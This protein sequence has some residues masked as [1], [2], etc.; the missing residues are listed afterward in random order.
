MDIPHRRFFLSARFDTILL[1]ICAAGM[2]SGCSIAMALNGHADPDFSHVQVGSRQEDIQRELGKPVATSERGNG[3][4]EE[5]YKYEI[6][7][8]HNPG[9]AT[10]YGYVLLATLGIAE[11]IL[12]LIELFQ[13][14]DEETRVVYDGSNRALEISGYRPPAASAALVAAQEAQQS[15]HKYSSSSNNGEAHPTRLENPDT[16]VSA[17]DLKLKDL[18]GRLASRMRS[19]G[20][21]RVAVLPVQ[22][23]SGKDNL[24]FGNYLTEKLTVKLHEEN[25]GKVIERTQLTKV[26]QEIA[27]THAGA[28]DEG[29][30]MRIGKLLGVEAVVT[31]IFADV[32]QASIEVTSKLVR[33]ETG[34]ILGAGSTALSRSSVERMLR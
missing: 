30:V 26:T 17:V 28:F 7:N 31:T 29:S 1:A 3:M 9:R 6:G 21:T 12:S 4:R 13:G 16:V 27:Q 24:A 15:F 19:E 8:S 22:D 5:T 20:I 33:V 10:V 34:E 25:V 32:G 11:P 14:S 18:V 23:A 2:L